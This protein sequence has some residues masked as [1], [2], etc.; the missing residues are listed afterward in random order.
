MNDQTK[1]EPIDVRINPG[2]RQ[3][4]IGNTPPAFEGVLST[5]ISR[6]GTRPASPSENDLVTIKGIQ[7]P[8]NVAE[9]EGYLVKTPTGYKEISDADRRVLTNQNELQAQQKW[10]AE[11]MIQLPVSAQSDLDTVAYGLT[12]MNLD[13]LMVFAEMAGKGDLPPALEH[14]AA[15][16]K[17]SSDEMRERLNGVTHALAAQINERVLIPNRIDNEEFQNWLESRGHG[18]ARK[19]AFIQAMGYGDLRGYKALAKLYMESPDYVNSAAI[20]ESTE[21]KQDAQ[22]K[23]LVRPKG[24][25]HWMTPGAAHLLK[26]G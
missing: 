9:R 23:T 6:D 21:V 1:S 12:Q 14:L 18:S 19:R 3:V 25:K 7:M 11:E 4:V 5:A 24:M 20:S 17:V 22:G 10:E 13:P 2:A 8:I 26:I 15:Q 16:W